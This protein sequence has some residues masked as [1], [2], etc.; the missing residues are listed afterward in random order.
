MW[1]YLSD[2]ESKSLTRFT[3]PG[4]LDF[5]VLTFL[6]LGLP[7]LTDTGVCDV[8]STTQCILV[9]THTDTDRFVIFP[10]LTG[11]V[12]TTCGV[13]VPFF[14]QITDLTLGLGTLLTTVTPVA[15]NSSLADHIPL[16]GAGAAITD[17]TIGRD[18]LLSQRDTEVP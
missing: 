13:F 6:D 9:V 10:R 17:P 3:W 14:G 11:E 16:V 2:Q 8:I 7:K 18:I 5:Q 15:L 4:V 1:F 12:V